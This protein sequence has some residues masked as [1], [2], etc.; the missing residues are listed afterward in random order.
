MCIRDRAN[1]RKDA[2]HKIT[3]FIASNFFHVGIED[4]HVK[5]MI[6]NHKLARSI[7]D[8]GMGEF[9]RQLEYKVKWREGII[10]V[11]NRFFPS[12]K[13]CMNC[14]IIKETLSLADRIFRCECGLEVDRDFN[15]ANNLAPLPKVLREFKPVEMAALRKSVHPV[16]VTS[17]A[18]TGNRH[19]LLCG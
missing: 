18:E 13:K 5:G 1:A 12:S 9:R 8:V 14:G 16:F 2:L 17:I 15:A 6:R 7:A 19:H 4:L 11:Y 3:T 10:L